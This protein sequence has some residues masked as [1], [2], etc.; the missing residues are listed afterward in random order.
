MRMGRYNV[1][2]MRHPFAGI[3]SRALRKSTPEY[4]A[5]LAE[6]ERL[7]GKGYPV[8]EIYAVLVSVQKSLIESEDGVILAEAVEEFGRY[9]EDDVVQ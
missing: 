4:N 7:K 9:R 2:S 6:A 8:E 5:V 1:L 3:F